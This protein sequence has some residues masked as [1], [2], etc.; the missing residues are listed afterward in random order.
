MSKALSEVLHGAY[1]V[2]GIT[3]FV[4]VIVSMAKG[5]EAP[6]TTGTLLPLRRMFQEAET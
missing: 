4:Q 5:G 2:A 6:L 3:D 1:N